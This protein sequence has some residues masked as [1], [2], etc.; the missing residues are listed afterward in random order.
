VKPQP[1]CCLP[2]CGK[3]PGGPLKTYVVNGERVSYPEGIDAH[4]WQGHHKGPVKYLCHDCHMAHHQLADMR[5]TF[6]TIDGKPYVYRAD[7]AEGFVREATV[8][9]EI[10]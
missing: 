6:G 8:F 7:G 5:L 4:H 2:W 1:F 9:D 10:A 3:A